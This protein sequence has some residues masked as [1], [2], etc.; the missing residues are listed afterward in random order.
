M[1]RTDA[2]SPPEPRSVGE[3]AD[4]LQRPGAVAQVLPRLSLPH[5]QVAEA[6]AALAPT[7]RDA[8]AELLGAMDEERARGLDAALRALADHALVWPDGE[9]LLRMVAPLRQAWDAPL[10]LDA[11]LRQLLKDTTSDELR[12]MLGSLGIK[13]GGTKQQRL[14]DLVEHH[15]DRERI[16]ELV[17]RAP[18]ATR[19]L[20]ERRARTAPERS[21]FLVFGAPGI[22]S[23]PDSRWALERG[24]LVQDRRGYGTARM[25]AE[26]ALALRGPGWRTPFEPAPPD[27][28]AMPVTPAEVDREA[29]AAAMAFGAHAAS[30][31]TV[32]AASPPA[33]LKSGGIGARELSRVCKAARCDDVVVRIV[34][35]TAYAAGLL[36]RDGD[37]VTATEGYDA[38][39]EQE[40]AEQ[41][42]VLLQAWRTLQLTPGQARDE[43]GK[44]LPTLA[45]TPPCDG[46]LQAREGLLAAAA[47]L[48]AGQGV[49]SHADLGPLVAWHRPLAHP[50]PQDATPF[51][52]VSREAEL[53]GVLARGA[54]SPIG[55]ALLDNDAEAPAAACRRLLPAATGT[56]RFG[57]DLTAVVTGTPS[58]RLTTLLDSVADRETGGTASVWRFSPGSVRRALDADRTPDAIEADLAAV[59]VEP[60]PQPLVYLIHDTARGHGRVRIAPAACVLHSEEHT[61]LAELAA[62]RKLAELGLR[63]LAPTVLVS[64][65]P[66][67]KTLAALRAAG[68]APV[69]ET[70]DGTV[71]VEKAQRH[72]AVAPVPSPRPPGGTSRRRKA[73][74]RTEQAPATADLRA[75]ATGLKTAPPASPQPDPYNGIPFDS[76]TE[77]IIAGLAR[78]LSLTDVRQLAHAVNEDQAITIEYVAA[79]GSRTIRTLSELDLD[80]P[81]LYAWCHLRNDER[82][83]TL[84]RIHGVMPG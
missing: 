15:S 82:V 78:Q 9:G 77:E 65:A 27:V 4:R 14:T 20:L 17:A 49:K 16:T 47:G 34:L 74:G 79:S 7:T 3:L 31:L 38:W 81:Y 13:S 70:A 75:L 54:L 44:A 71:R 22:D 21:E 67:E 64:R 51:A 36:A 10:G 69:A 23:E 25:P 40:P 56:A 72:R 39:A 11:P 63:H 60:L 61:L 68:Y 59:A 52:T 57:A 24:L 42:A 48:P 12:R 6:L 2:V 37:R 43:D 28:P 30:V 26:V 66:L 35:E 46:C 80:P 76:D 33:R 1:T 29:T 8:L 83:F 5:L 45:G 32:C 58:A 55:T 19:K 73:D 62:H 18:V 41:F 53:L 84:S 50:L